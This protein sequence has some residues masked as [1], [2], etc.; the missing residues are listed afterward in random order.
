MN[1][2]YRDLIFTEHALDRLSLRSLSQ[3]QIWQVVHHHRQHFE[4]HGNE[5]FI[6]TLHGRRVHVVAKKLPEDQ[7]WLVISVW[8]RGED[9]PIPWVWQILVFP[10]KVVWWIIKKVWKVSQKR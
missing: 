6:L 5:K 7:K 8:V 1:K 4:N 10:F 2:N 3:D 9:D